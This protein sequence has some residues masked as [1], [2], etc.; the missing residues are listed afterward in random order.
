MLQKIKILS[1]ILRW[2]CACRLFEELTKRRG[3]GEI[4][5]IVH[6]IAQQIATCVQSI[7]FQGL[8]HCRSGNPLHRDLLTG[9]PDRDVRVVLKK[10]IHP[11]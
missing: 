10:K 6:L 2:S 4:E 3:V 7:G 9:L 11:T 5:F 1:L 8:R